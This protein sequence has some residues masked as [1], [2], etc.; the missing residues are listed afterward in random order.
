MK[1]ILL[2][3]LLR[4][5][6]CSSPTKN[7]FT[8][9]ALVKNTN[10]GWR[11]TTKKQDSYIQQQQRQRTTNNY[12]LTT[13]NY[14]V[15]KT[16]AFLLALS[17]F[18]AT[19][20]TIRIADNNANRPTGANIYST[21]QAAVDAALPGETVYITPSLTNYGNVTISKRIKL[22]GVGFNTPELGGR[23]SG[24]NNITLL[25]SADG[26]NSVSNSEF[27]GF[28]FY[29]FMFTAGGVGVLPYNDILIENISGRWIT[30]SGAHNSINNLT[31]RNCY[32]SLGIHIERPNTDT[33]LYK[34]VILATVCC[35]FDAVYINNSINALVSNN[36]I[37]W[38]S[39]LSNMINILN[40]VNARF[41][42]NL[43]S[44]GGPAFRNLLNT[45]VTNNIFYGVDP[46][47]VNTSTTFRDNVFSHNLV[48]PGF[49]IPPAANGGGTN[50]GIGNI[51]DVSPLFVNGP[52]SATTWAG[53]YNY[54]F[55]NSS[56]CFQGATTG[57]N[58]GPSG[59]L[60]PL[61]VNVVFNPTAVPLITLFD[62]TGVVPQ[63][64][65][66]KSNIKAKAN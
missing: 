41:E 55:P 51:L 27:R 17:A 23:Y 57:D 5:F 42:H 47:T 64:Q 4:L 38:N 32:L 53:N 30:H 29:D 45:P 61:P 63:N 49:T 56:P 18:A 65:P 62:N 66:L 7:P 59:G 35:A 33:K 60:Y 9:F 43:V 11:P 52:P 37:Y 13:N 54:S 25:S 14:I 1:N 2:S 24:L 15:M 58:I 3:G 28:N 21:I 48:V 39:G 16:L 50:S 26:V 31:I 34:N 8:D 40:S 12:Q 19:A 46:R 22:V 10:A 20:Q 36:L 6:W 44:G